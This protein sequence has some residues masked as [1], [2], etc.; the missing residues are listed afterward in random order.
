MDIVIITGQTVT[1]KT[2]YAIKLAQKYNGEL[3]NCDSRQVYKKL[4][5]I[6]GKDLPYNSEFRIY[7][8]EL[9]FDIGYYSIAPLL[10]CSMVKNNE[11]M[12]QE[13]NVKLWLYDVISP[14][15]YFSSYDWVQCAIPV[16][17]DIVKR[18]KTPI[19]VGGTYLY[20]KHLLYGFA[21]ELIP[22]NWK[23]RNKLNDKSV[24]YLQ[25][26]LKKIN[27]EQFNR[28]N[29]SDK[30][31]PQRLIRKIEISKFMSLREIPIKSGNKA[32]SS[33]NNK[34]HLK[35]Y[36]I[37]L[38]GFYYKNKEKLRN[39]ITLRVEKRLKN[40]A[41]NEVKKLLKLGYQPTDPGLKTIGYQQ[42]IKYLEKQLTL[43]ETKTEWI[44]KEIQY[45]KRQY[46]FMKKDKNIVWKI[47]KY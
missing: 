40:G 7:N 44:N 43:D 45:A 28:L 27:T 36:N 31:N 15:Q 29:Y 1:G 35:N 3:I 32:I 21:T 10:H 33:T 22:P 13:N 47:T 37:K 34:L 38:I 42:I 9:N 24:I 20:I 39:N 2:S 26:M 8:S 46:T 11:T 23:L 25:D 4:D 14:N 19:I 5:I 12:K 17:Q 41:I 16:I 30:N 18:G 6:T